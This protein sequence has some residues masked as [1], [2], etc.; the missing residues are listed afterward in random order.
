MVFGIK[1]NCGLETNECILV[2]VYGSR[3]CKI[4]WLLHG[5]LT[6]WKVYIN[7]YFLQFTNQ[8]H[9]HHDFPTSFT[10]ARDNG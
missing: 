10:Y 1:I 4:L 8:Y 7:I 6:I 5:L 2:K 9:F 3:D